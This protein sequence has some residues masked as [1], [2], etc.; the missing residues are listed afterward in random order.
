MPGPICFQNRC[1]SLLKQKLVNFLNGAE[2]FYES[3]LK[4]KKTSLKM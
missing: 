3:N 2:R 4:K 1:R